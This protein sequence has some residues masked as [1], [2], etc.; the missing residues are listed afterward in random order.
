MP[1]YID[2]QKAGSR[3]TMRE[4]VARKVFPIVIHLLLTGY[5]QR[6]AHRGRV[7]GKRAYWFW[8]GTEEKS[9]K[10]HL[11]WAQAV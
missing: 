4:W 8:E 2:G 5:P 3:L 10:W 9:R 1:T 7:K 11:G 6:G